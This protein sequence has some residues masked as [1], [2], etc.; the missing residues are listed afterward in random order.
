MTSKALHTLLLELNNDK[1]YEKWVEK[2]PSRGEK[3]RLVQPLTFAVKNTAA[4]DDNVNSII[5]LFCVCF[6]Y[7]FIK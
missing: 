4:T 7:L 2:D 3:C 6:Y 1:S 5:L